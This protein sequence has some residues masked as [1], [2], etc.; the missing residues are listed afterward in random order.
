MIAS[1]KKQY[2]KPIYNV[3]R[4][5]AKMLAQQYTSSGCPIIHVTEGENTCNP[6][7]GQHT[8]S[9]AMKDLAP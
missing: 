2:I 3:V 8:V 1:V 9:A 6:G 5:D 7:Q 4:F